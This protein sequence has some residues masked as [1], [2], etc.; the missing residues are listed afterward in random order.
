MNKLVLRIQN[1]SR[2]NTSTVSFSSFKF[3]RRQLEDDISIDNQ[4]KL[5]C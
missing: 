1:L 5:S 2:S 4:Q 3:A